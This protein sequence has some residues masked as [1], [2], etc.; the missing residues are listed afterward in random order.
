MHTC[1]ESIFCLIHSLVA[2]SLVTFLTPSLSVYS[3]D[4]CFTC[5][6]F[7]FVGLWFVQCLKSCL[8][9]DSA[10]W[11]QTAATDRAATT[12]G[13]F[14]QPCLPDI[15]LA[16]LMLPLLSECNSTTPDR[17]TLPCLLPTASP[18]SS[19]LHK[20]RTFTGAHPEQQ[21]ALEQRLTKRIRAYSTKRRRIR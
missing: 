3:N 14:L 21:E 17:L 13:L 20:K 7:S 16:E 4:I 6:L 19:A 10:I 5:C 15:E 1:K 18:C 11:A 9:Y 8:V 12:G 2:A